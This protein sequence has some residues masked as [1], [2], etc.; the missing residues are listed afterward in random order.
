MTPLGQPQPQQPPL[1]TKQTIYRNVNVSVGQMN[2]E[3]VL[4]IDALAEQIVLP[5]SD[6]ASE[7]IG[8][9]LLAPH[10]VQATNGH[11]N[12]NGRR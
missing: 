6:E 7:I 11:V 1:P 2:N 5:M 12:G 4:V 3:R 9:A 10:I 8:K